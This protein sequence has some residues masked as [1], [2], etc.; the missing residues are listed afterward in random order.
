MAGDTAAPF[1]V[2]PGK[3]A[4]CFDGSLS[5]GPPHLIGAFRGERIDGDGDNGLMLMMPLRRWG[6]LSL[7]V[8]PFSSVARWH[9]TIFSLRIWMIYG[10]ECVVS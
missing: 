8:F 4:T 10:Q 9:E 5:L 7:P 6:A 1:V 3:A 2:E